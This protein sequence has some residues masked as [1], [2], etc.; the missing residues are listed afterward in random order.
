M[1]SEGLIFAEDA[2]TSDAFGNIPA[3]ISNQISSAKISMEIN[4]SLFR[5]EVNIFMASETAPMVPPAPKALSEAETTLEPARSEEV[6]PSESTLAESYFKKMFDW[7]VVE[8]EFEYL[9]DL[10]LDARHSPNYL[11]SRFDNFVAAK[12]LSELFNP[13]L[14]GSLPIESE[15]QLNSRVALELKTL[16]NVGRGTNKEI[17]RLAQISR[18]RIKRLN[19]R[20]TERKFIKRTELALTRNRIKGRFAKPKTS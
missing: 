9:K 7:S 11:L 3:S 5:I 1:F 19:R 18:Y 12:D 13:C 16:A 15:S 2:C 6:G 10:A 20:P 14:Q 4:S 8:T 17:Y